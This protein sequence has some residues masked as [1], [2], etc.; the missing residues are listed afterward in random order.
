M[1]LS[2]GDIQLGVTIDQGALSSA[3]NSAKGNV[4]SWA[5]GVESSFGGIGKNSKIGDNLLSS[6]SGSKGKFGAIGTEIGSSIT[7]SIGSSFGALGGVA[8][9]AATALGPVGIAAG[10]VAAGLL[11]IGSASVSAASAWQSGMAGVSKTTGLAGAD[12]DA[13]SSSLLEMSTRMPVAASGLQDIAAAGGS[14]GVAQSELAGFTEAATMM[15]VGFE[16]S[17]EAA[18]TSSAKILTAFGKPIDTKNMMALG[19]V[20]NSMGDNFA[21]TEP[22]V[23]DFIN[24]ASFLN[25]TMN[26]SIPSVAA[27]GTTLIS[28]GMEAEVAA[29][30]IKSALNMGMSETSKTGGLVNWAKLMGVSVDELKGK[31]GTDLSGT[32]V[33]TANKIASMEDPV[34]RFQTAVA[35]FGSE[36]A[37]AVLKLAGQ[38]DAL[39]KALTTA[40][41]EWAAGSSLQKTYTAQSE[42]LASRFSI[43]TNTLNMVAVSVGTPMLPWISGAVNALQQ[44]IVVAFNAG[45]AIVGIVKNSDAFKAL[46]DAVGNVASAVQTAFGNFVSLVQPAWDALGGG[47]AV[48]GV[49]QSAFNA[50]TAPITLVF[51]AL[52]TVAS[53]LGKVYS[54]VSPAASAVGEALG[55]AI[56]TTSAVLQAFMEAIGDLGPVKSFQSAIQG[57]ADVAGKV[58]DGLST[59][60]PQAF[61]GAFEAVKTLITGFVSW[62]GDALGVGDIG[63]K[64]TDGIKTSLGEGITGWI[65]SIAGRANELLGAGE[66]I[67]KPVADG[68][69]S[70]E[71]LQKAAA[72]ALQTPEALAA[73]EEAGQENAKK[74]ENGFQEQAALS[75]LSG[76]Q[77]LGMINSQSNDSKIKQ[78]TYDLYGKTLEY[79][80]DASESHPTAFLKIGDVEVSMPSTG[81]NL[82]TP[83]ELLAKLGLS[84]QI[85]SQLKPMAQAKIDNLVTDLNKMFEGASEKLFDTKAAIENLNRFGPELSAKFQLFIDDIGGLISGFPS[86]YVAP[87]RESWRKG[88][89]DLIDA[90]AEPMGLQGF[91]KVQDALA[92]NSNWFK[93]WGSDF[94]NYAT[95]ATER[96]KAAFLAGITDMLPYVNQECSRL[97]DEATGAIEDGFLSYDDRILLDELLAQANTL[98]EIAPAEFEA[99]GGEVTVALIEG[100]KSGDIKGPAAAKAKEATEAIKATLS[101]GASLENYGALGEQ[102]YNLAKAMGSKWTQGMQEDADA[103]MAEYKERLSGAITDIEAFTEDAMGTAG[104]LASK[105]FSDHVFT[106]DDLVSLQTN[107]LP[108]LEMVE[109]L[110]PEYFESAAGKSWLA[111]EDAIK[112]GD[113]DE[114][115]KAYKNL[116][117]DSGEAFSKGLLDGANLE[118]TL[119]QLKADPA[120]YAKYISNPMVYAANSGYEQ[121]KDVLKKVIDAYKLEG[122][123][124]EYLK[125]KLLEAFVGVENYIPG[126]VQR[127][128][129]ALSSNQI[130]LGQYLAYYEYYSGI[131]DEADKKTDKS[132]KSTE[133]NTKAV[134]KQAETIDVDRLALQ[135]LNSEMG[136]TKELSGAGL[137]I[138]FTPARVIADEAKNALILGAQ[139]G[140]KLL[141]DGGGAVKI[142]FD[143]W[144]REV[145]VIGKVAQEQWAKNGELISANIK[146]S[147]D[148]AA[149][150]T[151]AA[152]TTGKDIH[153]AGMTDGNALFLQNARTIN[154]ENKLAS[155]NFLNRFDLA[156][157]LFSA[158]I[159]SAGSSL[160]SQL[161]LAGGNL[162]SKIDIGATGHQFKINSAAQNAATQSNFAANYLKSQGV[163][164]ADYSYGKGVAAGN[165]IYE[166]GVGTANALKS[167]G[168]SIL[169]AISNATKNVVTKYINPT[170]A[171]KTT[172][173]TKTGP[174]GENSGLSDWGGTPKGWAVGTITK[175]PEMA[176]IGED[177]PAFP[178][179]VIPTKTKRWD[180]LKAAMAAYGIPGFAE[181]TATGTAS[182]TGSEPSGMTA[183]FGITGLASMA[184]DVKRIINDLKDFF[185][186]SWGIVKSEAAKYW[187]QI[188]EA[189]ST[190][191]TIIRDNGWQAA[192]DIRNAWISANAAIS[193]DAK[194]FWGGY[195]AAVEPSVS[196]IKENFVQSFSDIRTST[197]DAI[198]GMVLNSES[199][200]QNFQSTWSDI[201]GQLVTDMSDA[202]AK[203]TEGVQVIADALKSISVNVNINANTGSGGGSSGMDWDF[204]SDSDWLAPTGD[205]SDFGGGTYNISTNGGG[206]TIGNTSGSCTLTAGGCPSYQQAV[207]ASTGSLATAGLGYTG[208]SVYSGGSSGGT[209]SG[210]PSGY[211]L[212]A[213]F[214]AHG[215]LLDDGP[216]QVIAGEAGEELILPPKYTALMTAMAD[217]YQSAPNMVLP[218]QVKNSGVVAASGSSANIENLLEKLLEAVKGL[219]I[220][221]FIDSDEVGKRVM[222]KIQRK[223]GAG[224]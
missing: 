214:A 10:V 17:A 105:A 158:G 141:S 202:Q 150:T 31:I 146:T 193:E 161:N 63:T 23:L 20:V 185:R 115:I 73:A 164:A 110:S 15:S 88:A 42:T 25:T 221:V 19:N 224:L 143:Q 34:Q 215:A 200:L 192:L 118:V 40:N 171:T 80:W 159:Q 55:K 1:S 114:I 191:I 103:S 61:S 109:E 56:K 7:N 30:G 135:L 62:V 201:W 130:S 187:K 128:N 68:V 79:W 59:A 66:E 14:L 139:I 163:S 144:G 78:Y 2:V 140:S 12:L 216:N 33:E 204:G 52:G 181:G 184:K 81:L 129:A 183:T 209:Y 182:A 136:R 173:T 104:S 28:V 41:S 60:I 65:G 211:S 101:E 154:A 92:E 180:L 151:K 86:D 6:L 157:R 168:D 210:S 76:I 51:T 127:L 82:A 4:S 149:T 147:S 217:R 44:L 169:S 167:A 48:L 121:T 100:I 174:W 97:A 172:T 91:S 58:W 133:T 156:S 84:D 190:E 32:M 99:A 175:G 112:D 108:M 53:A 188:N 67:A 27:L 194:A 196:S 124:S 43:L 222:K 93:W 85:I 94:A 75:G 87:A 37:P 90:F 45:S 64:I 126:W 197:K 116:G 74:F 203:I 186:I 189:I 106:D 29:T 152:A 38:T 120:T 145:A 70:D 160:A 155:D 220:D 49:L 3:L 132:T 223:Q 178:E 176:V 35:L 83:Q 119:A 16:M 199:S 153:I 142:G 5:S 111:F 89:Q 122:M 125:S 131:L 134:K 137:T 213:I 107:L 11:A 205:W 8:S 198:D 39:N 69:K 177:G 13:L 95:D 179:F 166:K 212:P 206:C 162:Q 36:G 54:A 102:Y 72:E 21:A 47:E 219:G 123:D 218:T 46:E 71:D 138:S 26:M 77:L 98:K 18:A 24:R 96:Y 22:Q 148:S 113:P 195:W 50:V 165:W 57:A 117:K 9:T 208:G 170:T 207:I